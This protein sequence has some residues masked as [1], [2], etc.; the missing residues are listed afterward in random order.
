MLQEAGYDDFMRSGQEVV[1]GHEFTGRDRGTRRQDGGSAFLRAPHGLRCRC[2]GAV[3]MS[4][5]VGLSAAA[6]GAYAE[7]LLV[8]ESLGARGA[9]WA[10]A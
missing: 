2:C 1:L 6:P 7:A 5:S 8:E 9:E 3:A 4:T 10:A